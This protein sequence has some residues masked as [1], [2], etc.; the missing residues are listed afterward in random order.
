[1]TFRPPQPP[2]E[3]TRINAPRHV[4]EAAQVHPRTV[5]LRVRLGDAL[6][7]GL[8]VGVV[9]GPQPLQDVAVVPEGACGMW[10]GG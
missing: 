6:V 8:G 3:I 2:D 4:F 7:A 1:M 10:M 5:V 9:V